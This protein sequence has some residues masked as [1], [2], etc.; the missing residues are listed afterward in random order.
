MLIHS[1]HSLQIKCEG[2]GTENPDN[3]TKSPLQY[4]M[5][6]D[7][8]SSYIAWARLKQLVSWTMN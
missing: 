6:K 7:R 8:V 5:Y 1:Q 3:K 4:Y 2:Q